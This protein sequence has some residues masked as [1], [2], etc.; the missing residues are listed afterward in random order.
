MKL[1][2]PKVEF[3]SIDLK[4]NTTVNSNCSGSETAPGG[5]VTCSN[6]HYIKGDN[7]D[8]GMGGPVNC[9]IFC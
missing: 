9:G 5:G 6:S 1:N 3:V 4:V 8:C 7:E 2:E